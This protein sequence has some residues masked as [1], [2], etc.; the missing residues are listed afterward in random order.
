MSEAIGTCSA[1]QFEGV[2]VKPYENGFPARTAELCQVCARTFIG[3][4]YFYPK[5]YDNSGLYFALGYCTNLILKA[6]HEGKQ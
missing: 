4:A 1:C 2:P 6:I 3:N 5:Q